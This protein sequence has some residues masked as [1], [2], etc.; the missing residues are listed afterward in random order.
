MNFISKYLI[1]SIKKLSKKKIIPLH[2]PIFDKNTI[3]YLSKCVHT[4]FVSTIG[5]NIT[6]FEN[7]IKK[8]TG[9]KHCIAVV[10]GTSAL[11]LACKVLKVD[12]NHEVLVPSMT[13]VGTVNAI[14]YCN[15]I[16]H[17]V[18]IDEKNL[19]VD[20]KK[21]DL[22]LSKILN[23]KKNYSINK[24]T[25]R[26]VKF[27]IPVHLFGHPCNMDDCI[28]V[29]KK[30]KLTIIEDAAESLGS[31]Y[32]KRHVGTFGLAGIISFNGNKIITT[33]GGGA[34][35]TNSKKLANKIYH[36]STT[37]KIKSKFELSHD[38]IGYNFRLPNLNASLGCSQ[39]KKF[40]FFVKNKRKLFKKYNNLFNNNPYFYLLKENF[41]C[42]SNYWLQTI[43]LK[44]NFFKYKN[45]IISEI[46]NHGIQ[47]RPAWKLI[48]TLTPYKNSPRMDLSQSKNIYK[49]IINIPSSANL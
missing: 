15:A 32:K 3:S 43:I 36:L 26:I 10:N 41:F 9:A 30:Y 20:F 21:L 23:V 27:I 12:S 28:Y 6:L 18:D 25:N 24:K 34:V 14:S 13:F 1:S 8:I 47:V 16:P 35:L 33:G 17:F 11:F 38:Q 7:K 39:L 46:K 29:A 40:K 5:R 48:H 45:L 42:E 4:S 49:R 44:N 19:G 22:Y 2:E 37:A 31:F